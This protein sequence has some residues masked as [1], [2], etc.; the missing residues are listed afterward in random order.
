VIRVAVYE[1]PRL[2]VLLVCAFGRE[3]V[4]PLWDDSPAHTGAGKWG[5]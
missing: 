4:V 2:V 5:L 1:T 3:F